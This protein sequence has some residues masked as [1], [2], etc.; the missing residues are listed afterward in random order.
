MIEFNAESVSVFHIWN[1]WIVRE[2]YARIGNPEESHR[3]YQSVDLEDIILVL[4][5]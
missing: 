3:S 2:F 1:I 4:F 5:Q